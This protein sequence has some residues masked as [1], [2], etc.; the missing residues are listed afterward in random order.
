MRQRHLSFAKAGMTKA[1]LF[2]HITW[3]GLFHFARLR[4]LPGVAGTGIAETAEL[5][6]RNSVQS[7]AYVVTVVFLKRKRY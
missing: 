6:T 2:G 4:M 7:R 3:R 1:L 5:V